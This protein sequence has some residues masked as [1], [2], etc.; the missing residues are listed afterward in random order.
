VPTA[1]VKIRFLERANLDWRIHQAIVVFGSK[2][3]A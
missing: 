1:F 3:A 2:T